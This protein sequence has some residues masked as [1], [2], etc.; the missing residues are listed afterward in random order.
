MRLSALFLAVAASLLVALPATAARIEHFKK[1]GNWDGGAY[2]HTKTGK[3]NHC[4]A[5]ASYRNGNSLVFAIYKDR[6]W[7]LGIV[8]MD[9]KLKVDDTYP[10]RYRIDSGSE[11][12]GEATA[13]TDN[14]IKLP[15]PGDNKLFDRMRH[16]SLLTI[17][18]K[19]KTV[20][21]KLTS[22]DA[23]LTKLFDCVNTW[24]KRREYQ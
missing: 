20:K 18:L 19:S 16:G 21:F 9:W 10:V 23:M 15:L 11:L 5:S 6:S 22:T 7:A 13:A 17:N 4:A 8:N 24:R 1:I 3:F 12:S 2:T 14:Q